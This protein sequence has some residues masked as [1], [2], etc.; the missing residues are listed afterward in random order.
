MLLRALATTTILAAAAA[1]PATAQAQSP[2]PWLRV[3]DGVTQPV[4]SAADAIEETVFVESAADSDGDGRRDRVRIQISRPAETAS[5]DVRVPVVFEQSP[6]RGEFGEPANNPVD[7]DVLPQELERGGARATRARGRASA[8]TSRARARARARADLPGELDDFYVPRGYAVVLGESLGT[9][10]SDG[11]PTVGDPSEALATVAVID[12]LN[13]RARG[14]DT[15]G[16][17]VSAGWTTGDVGMVGTSYDGTLATMAATT[18]VEGLRAIVPVAAISR[19]YDYYRSNGLVVAPH[20]NTDAAGENA[21]QGEDTDV[22]ALFSAPERMAG[23]CAHVLLRLREQQNRTNGDE[24]AF[25]RARDF[26]RASTI[27]AATLLV[28]GLSDFNVRTGQFAGLWERLRA[29]NVPRKL[30]LHDRGHIYP[31]R[32]PEYVRTEHRWFD[33]WLFGVANGVDTEPRSTIRPTEG[34]ITT[35]ADWPAPGSAPVELRLGA[36][37]ATD[38]GAL[39]T[40]QPRGR[41][42]QR[43]VDRGRERDV[44]EDLMLN[45]DAAD[46][47]RLVF[48]T[49]A[50]RG[51]VRFSGTPRVTL[52]AGVENRRAANL[53][54][55][56]V[57]YGPAGATEPPEMVTRGWIDVQNRVSPARTTPIEPGRRYAFTF[58]LQANDHVFRAGHR[59]GLVVVSTDRDHTLRPRPG[60][61]LTLA[62][63]ASELELPLVGGEAAL[64]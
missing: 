39:T 53:T 42:V 35:D 50:L 14:F 10:G 21:Y 3:A 31:S 64:G 29:A 62:P 59:I 7:F 40:T 17:P 55:V 5:P 4:F 23:P 12:W 57:D 13:G 49:D 25:W 54:A 44:D 32:F 30:F 27:R 36:T 9:A 19:W 63:A 47:N 24:T 28:H 45:P 60:T 61:E 20:S 8:A 51:A 15:A 33:R 34:A 18:G 58:D 48:R 46:P 41:T 6:Y 2:P 16:N 1:L 56:L 38:P 22:L 11:C 26:R 43:F 52:R 37:N